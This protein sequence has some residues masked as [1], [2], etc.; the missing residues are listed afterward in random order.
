MET[1]IREVIKVGPFFYPAA[2][3]MQFK[4]LQ[5]TGARILFISSL[6]FGITTVA[7]LYLFSPLFSYWFLGTFRFWKFTR[8]APRLIVYAYARAYHFLKKDFSPLIPFTAP[9]MGSP[10]PSLVPFI[11]K[12][13]PIPGNK[14]RP[15]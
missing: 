12:T 9:P 5:W 6:T 11:K 1:H 15:P 8:I 4:R 2:A 7:G 14:K 13:Q 3:A 10:D